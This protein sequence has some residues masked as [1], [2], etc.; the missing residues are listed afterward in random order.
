MAEPFRAIPTRDRTEV[1][2]RRGSWSLMVAAADLRRWLDLYRR[3]RDRNAPPAPAGAPVKP[4][5]YHGI[6]AP[7]VT[8]LES[9]LRTCREAGTV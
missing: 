3:L 4:G 9:A 1:L 5:P 6:Y 2:L 7:A 8:E